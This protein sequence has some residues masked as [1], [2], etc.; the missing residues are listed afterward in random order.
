[1]VVATSKQPVE[2]PT[3][4][5]SSKAERICLT[6]IEAPQPAQSRCPPVKSSFF[7]DSSFK[8]AI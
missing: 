4:T 8:L 2:A 5:G 7:F 1:M 3:T 6:A